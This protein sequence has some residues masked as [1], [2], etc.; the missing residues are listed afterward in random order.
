MAD[1]KRRVKATSIVAAN[2]AGPA[3]FK[4]AAPADNTLLTAML[5]TRKSRGEEALERQTLKQS[6]EEPPFFDLA[7]IT[8]PL[9][10][11]RTVAS[12]R[13]LPVNISAFVPSS[14]FKIALGTGMMR[15]PGTSESSLTGSPSAKTEWAI[16][17]A[18]LLKWALAPAKDLEQLILPAGLGFS[19]AGAEDA[20]RAPKGA[21]QLGEQKKAFDKE[22]FWSDG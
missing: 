14:S 19:V 10:T 21:Y 18:T 16:R 3:K 8:A 13:A 11:L 22:R 7:S 2:S 5:P 1:Y 9:P 4:T 6:V 20:N 15:A 12:E 17:D